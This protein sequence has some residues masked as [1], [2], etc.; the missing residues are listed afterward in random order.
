M[1][2]VPNFG[3]RFWVY[4]LYDARTDQFAGIGKP[5]GT[6]PGFYMMVGPDWEGAKPEG[7]TAVVRSSTELAFSIPRIFKGDSA[8]E[9]KAVQPLINQVMLYPLSQFDGKMKTTDWSQLPNWPTPAGA[10]GETKWV[11]PEKFYEQLPGV[12]KLVA[13]MPGEA[14]LYAWI[15]SVWTAAEK[16]PA[17]KDALIESFVAADKDTIAPFS[18]GTR[19]GGPWATAGTHRSTMRNGVTTISIAPRPRSRICMITGRSRRST[20]IA[21]TTARAVSTVEELQRVL[22]ACRLKHRFFSLLGW[23]HLIDA[24]SANREALWNQ[25]QRHLHPFPFPFLG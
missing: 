19:T 13:P 22:I 15:G 1:F 25:A 23:H 5:Y 11:V 14:S 3:D 24:T 6:K 10:V 8:Q 21:T 2:Q 20:S 4:A 17:M 9:T 12:M 18:V 16:D 7:I